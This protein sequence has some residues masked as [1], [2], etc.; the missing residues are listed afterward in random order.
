MRT[1]LTSGIGLGPRKSILDTPKSTK[2]YPI[3]L[4][5]GVVVVIEYAVSIP[6]CKNGGIRRIK[7]DIM[8]DA[9]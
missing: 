9:E 4:L 1:F 3:L 6:S 5:V 2:C 8:E 7:S